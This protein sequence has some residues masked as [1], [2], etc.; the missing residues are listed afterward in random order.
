MNERIHF[1][2]TETLYQ[3]TGAEYSV[4]SNEGRQMEVH[5]SDFFCLILLMS[6]TLTVI[7]QPVDKT[8]PPRRPFIHPAS[9]M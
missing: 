8:P 2:F 9:M 5:L 6:L 1:V 3:E 7:K 4:M